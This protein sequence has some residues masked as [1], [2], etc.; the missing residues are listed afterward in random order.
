MSCTPVDKEDPLMPPEYNFT[1][2]HTD[3]IEIYLKQMICQKRDM[4]GRDQ[5]IMR[6]IILLTLSKGIRASKPTKQNNKEHPGVFKYIL[7]ECSCSLVPKV[8]CTVLK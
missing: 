5:F 2:Q 3:H 7:I 4:C 1:V 8:Q 6:L